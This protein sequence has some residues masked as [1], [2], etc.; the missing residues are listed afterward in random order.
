MTYLRGRTLNTFRRGLLAG[1]LL[2]GVALT[3]SPFAHTSLASRPHAGPQINVGTKNFGEEYVVSD[4]YALLLQKHGFSVGK[5]HTLATTQLLQKALTRGQIDLYPEY[6]GTGLEVVLGKKGTA[7]EAKA[8]ATV[9]KLYQERFHLT[10]LKAAEMNDTNGVA[11]TQATARKYH[12]KS[13]SDLAKVGSKIHFAAY[14]DCKGR[15]DCLSGL[16]NT[17]HIKF[18]QISYVDSAPILYKGLQ[19]GTYNAIEVF[20]TDGP[21]KALK[22]TLLSDPKGIFPAD[23]VAP[24]V[25][26]SVLQKYPKIAAAL[27]PLAKVLTTSAVKQL[28]VQV[29]LDGKDPMSV[30]QQF[31]KSKGLL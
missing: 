23:H 21:L 16:Q 19:D 8:Y 30:A 11:V 10:W 5:T 22:P 31:L 25:R 2:S 29:V 4:M 18:G 3:A 28:N 6:T 26:A 15:A 1:A 9:K 27:N 13:L 17:Y 14:P 12:L 20:T 7:S 24:V